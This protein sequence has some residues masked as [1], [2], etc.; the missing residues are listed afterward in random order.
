MQILHR[1]TH[2]I[3]RF[4]NV[5]HQR[6]QFGP[7]LLV[8]FVRILHFPLPGFVPQL[9]FD[10]GRVQA[11]RP[12]D[13]HRWNAPHGGPKFTNGAPQMFA[14][15]FLNPIVVFV[16]PFFHVVVV[17]KAGAEETVETKVSD[18]EEEEEEEEKE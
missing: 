9:Q 10:V 2:R 1:G 14:G 13:V 4:T 18:E 6:I 15:N 7:G 11:Q 8:H 3:G 5:F 17:R 16:F 12:N